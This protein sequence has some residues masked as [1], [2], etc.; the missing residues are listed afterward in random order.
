MWS[1]KPISFD[2]K[3]CG[4]P[5]YI[6]AQKSPLGKPIFEKPFLITIEAKKDDFI[7]VWGQALAEMVA[8][9]KLNEFSSHQTV[10]GIVANGKFWEFGKLKGNGFTKNIKPYSLAELEKLFG[11]LN[12]IF[13]QAELELEIIDRQN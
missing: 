10:F 11:A 8:I 4:K 12:Y 2:D 3:L 9:Q 13:H 1:H 5:D 6:V 7:A